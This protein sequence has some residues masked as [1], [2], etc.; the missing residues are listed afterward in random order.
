MV[1]LLLRNLWFIVLCMMHPCPF[2]LTNRFIFVVEGATVWTALGL[3]EL[4]LSVCVSVRVGRKGWQFLQNLES[5]FLWIS[6]IILIGFHILIKLF[7]ENILYCELWSVVSMGNGGKRTRILT[8]KWRGRVNCL[9][10]VLLSILTP[11]DHAVKNQV[12]IVYMRTQQ[13]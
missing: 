3:N 6:I 5:L 11:S 8:T 4:L 9:W 2:F 13:N 1:F 12:S 10:H 7:L